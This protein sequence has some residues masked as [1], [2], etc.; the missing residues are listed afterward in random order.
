MAPTSCSPCLCEP[1]TAAPKAAAPTPGPFYAGPGATTVWS[2]NGDIRVADCRSPH[3]TLEGNAANAR[4]LA[5]CSALPP[6]VRRAEAVLRAQG[7][8]PRQHSLRPLEELLFD[9]QRLVAELGEAA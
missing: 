7:V 5:K 8:Q 9:L 3:L 4:F 1:P 6:V 2:G